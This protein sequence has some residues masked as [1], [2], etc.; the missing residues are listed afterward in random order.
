MSINDMFRQTPTFR[1]GR[2]R[3]TMGRR[4]ETTAE[5]SGKTAH[6]STRSGSL[7]QACPS[8]AFLLRQPWIHVGLRSRFQQHELPRLCRFQAKP[9]I[10]CRVTELTQC[11]TIWTFGLCLLSRPKSSQ[12]SS[13]G[14]MRA[15]ALNR[16]A[17]FCKGR[18]PRNTSHV[19]HEVLRSI[20]GQWIIGGF[21]KQLEFRFLSI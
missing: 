13:N 21:G 2:S 18:Y 8:R 11:G 5:T 3:I 16:S 15:Y 17:E 4:A 10:R 19:T 9:N 14:F 7:D 12:S 6:A 20:C 1:R